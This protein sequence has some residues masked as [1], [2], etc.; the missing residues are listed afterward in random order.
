MS[1]VLLSEEEFDQLNIEWWETSEERHPAEIRRIIA[2]AAARKALDAVR[3]EISTIPCA[4]PDEEDMRS[5][6]ADV[7]SAMLAEL[8]EE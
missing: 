1:D 7:I 3:S 5:K 2:K 4:T 8:G 6:V